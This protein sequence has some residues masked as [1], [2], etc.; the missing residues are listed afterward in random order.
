MGRAGQ[1]VESG[2]GSTWSNADE[3]SRASTGKKSR[4]A[5]GQRQM[6]TGLVAVSTALQLLPQHKPGTQQ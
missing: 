3:K 6:A 2:H 5:T 1:K 4:T